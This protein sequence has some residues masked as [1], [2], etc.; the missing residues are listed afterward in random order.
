MNTNNN[1]VLGGKDDK[2][3]THDQVC[4]TAEL[5]ATISEQE[6]KLQAPWMGTL[7]FHIDAYGD[8]NY[9]K[10]DNI[11]DFMQNS[12]LSGHIMRFCPVN[13]PPNQQEG[14]DR[15][16]RDIVLCARE[17]G[18]ELVSGGGNPPPVCKSLVCSCSLLV[19]NNGKE[20]AINKENEAHQVESLHNDRKNNRPNGH[21]S[22]PRRCTT[23]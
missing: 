14:F 8:G 17:H 21:R 18:V 22:M 3:P 13:Y 4:F 11:L 12:T 19:K 5:H 2:F 15:L 9:V 10:H 6:K 7:P 23:K 20:N 16:A 1:T